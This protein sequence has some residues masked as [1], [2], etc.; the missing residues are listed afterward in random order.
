V[1]DAVNEAKK[2]IHVEFFIMAWVDVTHGFF[3]ALAKAVERGVHM[4]FGLR[5]PGRLGRSVLLS[6]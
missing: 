1:T 4:R 3:E 2:R 5:A 6:R